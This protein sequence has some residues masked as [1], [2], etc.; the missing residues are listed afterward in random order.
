MKKLLLI[1]SIFI[2]SNKV[3]FGAINS[4][5]APADLKTSSSKFSQEL[6]SLE[7]DIEKKH[8][9]LMQEIAQLD[10]RGRLKLAQEIER[11]GLFK[12]LEELEFKFGSLSL[13][14]NSEV[15]EY[16]SKESMQDDKDVKELKK[17]EEKAFVSMP[18]YPRLN[19]FNSVRLFPDLTNAIKRGDA[20]NLGKILKRVYMSGNEDYLKQAFRQD[21]YAR[22]I[23]ALAARYNHGLCVECIIN[24]LKKLENRWVFRDK[25]FLKSYVNRPDKFGKTAADY[26]FTNSNAEVLAVLMSVGATVKANTNQDERLVEDAKQLCFS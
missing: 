12:P 10:R 18:G 15:K 21:M 2:C 9:E 6:K 14:D 23:L 5:Q 25:N 8:S 20:R 16:K 3:V 26:A 13:T 1:F 24:F 19:Y 17:P 4:K 7:Q 22:T 11:Q